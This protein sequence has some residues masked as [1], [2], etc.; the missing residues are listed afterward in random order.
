LTTAEI[1]LLLAGGPDPV[2]D[3]RGTERLLLDLAAGG[4]LTRAPLGQDAIW[5]LSPAAVSVS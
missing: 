4:S 2:A 5:R 1:A 3:V